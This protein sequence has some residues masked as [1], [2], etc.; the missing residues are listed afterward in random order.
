MPWQ[1]KGI[2]GIFEWDPTA[3]AAQIF[4][5]EAGEV[6]GLAVAAEGAMGVTQRFSVV[7]AGCSG[8]KRWTPAW[9]D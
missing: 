3:I 7:Q 9:G 8:G 1:P 5:D 2:D 4:G 6:F